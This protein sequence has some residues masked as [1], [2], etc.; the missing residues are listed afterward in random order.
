[1][2]GLRAGRGTRCGGGGEGADGVSVCADLP[3][4]RRDA[5]LSPAEIPVEL[6]TRYELAFNLKV[7]RTL[8]LAIPQSVLLRADRV[9]E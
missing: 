9:V 5:C 1:M 2:R 3:W 7:A 4:N 6:P 8:G